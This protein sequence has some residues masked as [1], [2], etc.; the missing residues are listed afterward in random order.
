MIRILRDDDHDE[1]YG[2]YD[3]YEIYDE[4]DDKD[5]GSEERQLRNRSQAPSAAPGLRL[6]YVGGSAPAAN[7]AKSSALSMSCTVR[8]KSARA[9]ELLRTCISWPKIGLTEPPR[10]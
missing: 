6:T 8:R 10:G 3:D 5:Q 2:R 7:A 1:D 9:G 4:E